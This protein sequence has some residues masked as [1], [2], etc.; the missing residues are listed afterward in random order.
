MYL[1]DH[2]R[3]TDEAAVIAT[4]TEHPLAVL[5][6]HTAAGLVANHLPLLRLGNDRLVGH[7]AKANDVHETAADG[8]EVLAIFRADDAYV[9]P[10]WYPTKRDHHRH[11][12]TWN[13]QV[14]HVHGTITFQH[15]DRSKRA[16]VGRL[17]KAMETRAHTD[18]GWA[19]A[20]APADYLAEMLAAIVAFEIRIDRV[21]AKTKA[22]QNRETV[23]RNAAADAVAA[24]GHDTLART[25]RRG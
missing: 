17:T 15:D 6:A 3:E 5:V 18:G 7:V 14:V 13:Y 11:V 19:M 24:Q 20:D 16:A 2:F 4:I 25:M 10:Q 8:S 21:V 1:P 12:P 9:S 22:S 23:D